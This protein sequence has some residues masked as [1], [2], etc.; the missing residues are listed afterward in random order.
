MFP[1]HGIRCKNPGRKLLIL[2]N[3]VGTTTNRCTTPGDTLA[4]EIRRFLSEE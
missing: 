3:A 2:K 4:S 1:R